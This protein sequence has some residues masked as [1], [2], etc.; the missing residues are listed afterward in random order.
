MTLVPGVLAALY[1]TASH[2]A[3]VVD[4]GWAETRV[5][6]VFKGIPLQH[7]YQGRDF[8]L[9]P[10]S[11][12]MWLKSDLIMMLASNPE[13]KQALLRGTSARTPQHLTA[14]S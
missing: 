4:C 2:S 3:L 14:D 12:G 8:L 1:A 11:I 7:L 13:R 6:P 9:D 10:S 5:L